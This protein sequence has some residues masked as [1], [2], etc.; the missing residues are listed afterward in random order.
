MLQNAYASPLSS[1]RFPAY[2]PLEPAWL[3]RKTGARRE[4]RRFGRKVWDG[5]DPVPSDLS[6]VSVSLEKK[7][8]SIDGLTLFQLAQHR[9]DL[10]QITL[11]ASSFNSPVIGQWRLRNLET[12]HLRLTDVSP[13]LD[14]LLRHT[15]DLYLKELHI[16]YTGP[17][18]AR[19]D[20]KALGNLHVEDLQLEGFRVINS[21][22]LVR[23]TGCLRDCTLDVSSFDLTFFYNDAPHLRFQRCR[24]LQGWSWRVWLLIL[25]LLTWVVGNLILF[26]SNHVLEA[27]LTNSTISISSFLFSVTR[28]KR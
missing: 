14:D 19:L 2:R 16:K 11:S 18:F 3:W 13:G 10:R 28:S 23:H 17:G 12:L 6:S 24:L 21:H 8:A 27:A 22:R 5:S 25:C 15:Q 26:F 7:T 20:A 9:P 1:Y 4:Y